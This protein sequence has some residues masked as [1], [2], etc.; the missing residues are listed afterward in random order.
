MRPTF[1]WITLLALI[2]ADGTTAAHAQAEFCVDT[3]EEF[4][5]AYRTSAIQPVTIRMAEGVWNMIGSTIDPSRPNHFYPN[6]SVRLEGGYNAN[7]SNRSNAPDATVLTAP[8]IDISAPLAGAAALHVE[9]ITI[10]D[11]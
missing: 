11:V 5:V 3:V 6:R 8:V 9:R 4:D 1:R 10:R 7:C 2:V